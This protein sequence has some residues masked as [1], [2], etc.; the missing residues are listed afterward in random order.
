MT[1][2]AFS[3]W[4][5]EP[6]ILKESGYW[7][8]RAL[9]KN[10]RRFCRDLQTRNL[11]AQPV[12]ALGGGAG[13]LATAWLLALIA[14]DAIVVPVGDAD[15]DE[16]ER[17]LALTQPELLITGSQGMRRLSA[18]GSDY[19]LYAE[20][21]R[22]GHAGLV[23]TSS[24]STGTPKAAVHDATRL[25]AKFQ[26]PRP[27]WR[28]LAFLQLDHIGGLNTLFHTLAN[29][30]TLVVP[31]GRDPESVCAAI[32]RHRV[33]LLPTTP[34][35]LRL[36]LVSE[37]FRRYDLTSLRRITYGTEPMPAAVLERLHATFPGVTLQQTYGMSE[38]GILRTKSR[39]DGSLWV[40]LGGEGVETK[41]VDGT[42]RV[43]SPW[44]MLG[45]LNAPSPFDA[46]G[47]LDTQ[48]RVEVDT[49]DP[50][51]VRILG[52]VTDV[53]TVGG[54]K[55]YPAEVESVLLAMPGVVD[56]TVV[57]APHGLMGQVVTAKVVGDVQPRAVQAF[58]RARLADWKVPVRVAVVDSL[59]TSGRGKKVRA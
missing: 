35:F 26:T 25:L 3:A 46:A 54:Q 52:R 41:V 15:G 18:A 28:T 7:T 4:K 53:I 36:L 23:L 1:V 12:V 29:G 11:R 19:P 48:D 10:A 50:R 59:P 31:D 21:R 5:N 8:W 20:L 56:A 39:D 40:Q 32:A 27:A 33:E 44:A 42:L 57:G 47:W 24:G 14:L 37:A 16:L 55:V 6:V 58:C 45:Y 13:S 34:T 30:G 17:I 38:V 2:H 49:T 22:L 43:R 9:F 51:W